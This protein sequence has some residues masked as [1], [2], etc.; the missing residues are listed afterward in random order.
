M[1]GT[2]RRRITL[3]GKRITYTL[4]RSARARVLR[5]EIALHTG[6][7]VT[8]PEGM[9]ERSVWEFLHSRRRWVV[10]A[11]ERIDRLGAILP[12]RDLKHGTLV[13][14]LGKQLILNLSVGRRPCVG[15]LGDSL[16]V[17]V[18]RRVAGTVRNALEVWYRREAAREFEERAGAVARHHGLA[19]RKVIIRS[20]RRRWG[21]CSSRGT[22]SFNWRILLAPEAVADYLVAHELAHIENPDHSQRFWAAVGKLYPAFR[23]QEEWLRKNGASLRL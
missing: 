14:C 6:L 7:R 19:Y 1:S 12:D 9:N 5:A 11:L 16:I 3:E 13:P 2:A 18:P 4:R 21:S 15:R 17:H 20:Q 8:L 10:G 23:E 22:L